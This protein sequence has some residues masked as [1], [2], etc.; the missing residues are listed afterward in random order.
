MLE[1][2]I[3]H[4]MIVIDKKG[5]ML[6]KLASRHLLPG[7]M[8]KGHEVLHSNGNTYEIKRVVLDMEVDFHAEP[9]L[10]VELLQLEVK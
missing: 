1:N 6:Q 7:S 9:E 10:H 4:R 2:K 8:I 5:K 3:K